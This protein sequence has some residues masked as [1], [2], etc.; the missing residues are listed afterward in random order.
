MAVSQENK[1]INVTLSKSEYT[2]VEKLAKAENRSVS[3]MIKTFILKA[4]K[5]S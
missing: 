4:I 2:E 1:R 5:K 3:N